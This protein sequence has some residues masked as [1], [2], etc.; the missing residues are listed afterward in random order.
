MRSVTDRAATIANP[1]QYSLQLLHRWAKNLEV[2][3]NEEGFDGLIS[4]I[5]EEHLVLNLF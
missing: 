4:V 1:M 5:A 3:R 2:I